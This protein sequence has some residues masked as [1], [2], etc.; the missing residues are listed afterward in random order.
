MEFHIADTFTDR[1]AIL[2]LHRN[3]SGVSKIHRSRT[4]TNLTDYMNQTS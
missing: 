1:L 2:M 3:Y 4:D